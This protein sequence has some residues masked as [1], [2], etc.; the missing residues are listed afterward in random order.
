M[1][2]SD[3]PKPPNVGNAP[4]GLDPDA[5]PTDEELRAA[6]ALRR[7]LDVRE[8]H[9]RNEAESSTVKSVR[10][11]GHDGAEP[12]GTAPSAPTID[13]EARATGVLAD[14]LRAAASLREISPDRHRQILDRALSGGER[15]LRSAPSAQAQNLAPPR[16]VAVRAAKN[17]VI[18]LA[19]GGA[20]GLLAAA[21]AV[22]LV[23]RGA[24]PDR[25]MGAKASATSA[26]PV[27]AMSRSTADLFPQGI[28]KSGGTTERVDRIAYARAQDFR[29]NQFARWGAP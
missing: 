4:D 2:P 15:S 26:G 12:R 16:N 23:L 18:Y 24:A 11:S 17:K 19:F 13:A 6:E 1:S 21:A 9:S 27:L 3:R 29:Q 7:V 8:R 5:P 28:A 20:A 10:G 25:T 22:V 14:A